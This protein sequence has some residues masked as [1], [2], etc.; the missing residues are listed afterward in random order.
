MEFL[1][2]RREFISLLGGAAVAWPLVARAQQRGKLP[3]IGF[4][5][6]TTAWAQRGN[7]ATLYP[8][9]GELPMSLL[10]GLIVRRRSGF[11]AP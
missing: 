11:L 3:T 1:R 5:G 10:R 4:W 2:R 7:G 9:N 8:G 6:A